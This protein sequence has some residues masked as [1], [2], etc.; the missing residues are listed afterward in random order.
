MF[1]N[2]FWYCVVTSG[3]TRWAFLCPLSNLAE[4]SSC[5]STAIWSMQ[6]TCGFLPPRAKL[7]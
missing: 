7:L 3:I 4:L 6:T 2:H 5:T 1:D